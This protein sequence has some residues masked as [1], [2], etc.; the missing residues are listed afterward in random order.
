V[1]T[2][3]KQ[4]SWLQQLLKQGSLNLESKDQPWMMHAR[5]AAIQAITK[6]PALN[7]QHEAWRYTSIEDLLEAK[8]ELPA[9]QV[10]IQIQDIDSYLLSESDAYRVLIFNGKYI[11]QYSNLKELP[12]GVSISSLGVALMNNAN[13]FSTWFGRIANRNEHVFTAL[14]TALSHDGVLINIL[15]GVDL[16]R[17]IELLYI[18]KAQNYPVLIQPRNLVVLG[19]SSKVTLI[20]RF[21][22]QG[23]LPY[24][25]NNVT[26][27]SVGKDASLSHYRVQSEN[28]NAYHLSGLYLSQEEHSQYRG[29]TLVFGSALARTEY[30]VNFTQQDAECSLNGLCVVG[31]KQLA[32]FHLEI[33]HRVPGCI[34]RE[35]FK[36]ILYGKGRAV[37]DGRI[38]VDKGAQQ[39]DAQLTNDNLILTREAEVDTKPQL[40]IYADDVKCSHGTT[41]GQ[42]DPQQIFYMCSRGI[43]ENV[44]RRMLCLGFAIEIIDTIDVPILH[45][46]SID[47]LTKILSNNVNT[48]W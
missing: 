33:N 15:D 32:D 35:Q 19:D 42:L 39:T 1:I 34:S 13:V 6:L 43:N 47:K 21:V 20:E 5:E 38:L 3:D 30:I 24:F 48:Q 18:N 45:A 37:F 9:E 31:N 22:G 26:E 10:D 8:F 44:A 46:Y 40:E 16:D 2:V 23:N 41:V 25:H 17:P 4:R 28:K 29:T 12:E 14:N 7:R 27:I 36:G 11:P